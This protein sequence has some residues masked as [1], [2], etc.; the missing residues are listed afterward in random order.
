MAA[1]T[2]QPVSQSKPEDTTFLRYIAT[3]T[4]A[5]AIGYA[6]VAQA[7]TVFNLNNPNATMLASAAGAAG[8]T[9]L[10]ISGSKPGGKTVRL[11]AQLA[12]SAAFGCAAA[13]FAV[14][15][16][17]AEEEYKE[18]IK[19]TP[20]IDART[21]IGTKEVTIAD[22]YCQYQRGKITIQHNGQEMFTVCPR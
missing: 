17:T 1:D 19:N 21:V 4:G 11:V 20:T 6:A 5:G 9:F 12:I 8:L 16:N 18:R 2:T 3:G 15:A 22:K 10:A 7:M 13:A 14:A